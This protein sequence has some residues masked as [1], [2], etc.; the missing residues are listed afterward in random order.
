MGRLAVET[1]IFPLYEVV[2]GKYRMTVKLPEKLRPVKDYIK[3]QGRFRHLGP[4]ELEF[5]QER[6]NLEFAKLMQKVECLK[7]WT[8]L[9][10]QA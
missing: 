10:R 2:D 7:S 8:E 6:V 4:P 5:I 1:G 9:A 3:L